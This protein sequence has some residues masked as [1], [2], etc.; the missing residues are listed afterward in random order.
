MVGGAPSPKSPSSDPPISIGALRS[1]I[2]TLRWCAG[3]TQLAVPVAGAR[4]EWIAAMYPSNIRMRIA[5]RSFALVPE[6]SRIT[7]HVRLPISPDSR[8]SASR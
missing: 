3:S 1:T 5:A 4:I 8:R 7:S 2:V 6:R